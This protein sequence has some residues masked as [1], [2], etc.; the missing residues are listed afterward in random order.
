M[1]LVNHTR[2]F[3]VWSSGQVVNPPR[4]TCPHCVLNMLN[5]CADS[6]AAGRWWFGSSFCSSMN[7]FNIFNSNI[8][9]FQSLESNFFSKQHFY[10]YFYYFWRPPNDS[11]HKYQLRPYNEHGD[12][13]APYDRMTPTPPEVRGHNRVAW[14]PHS[15]LNTCVCKHTLYLHDFHKTQP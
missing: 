12:E 6:S 13:R 15:R 14:Q 2:W 9:C 10:Y 1:F 11:E 7:I 4:S 5:Q 8:I 3:P